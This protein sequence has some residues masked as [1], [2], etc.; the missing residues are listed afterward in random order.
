V[1]YRG[2]RAREHATS[3][4]RLPTFGPSQARGGAAKHITRGRALREVLRAVCGQTSHR[5]REKEHGVMK[6]IVAVI[7]AVPHRQ[8]PFEIACEL[9]E[10]EQ[11]T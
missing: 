2:R 6:G 7:T 5:G 9:I 10:K 1:F 8:S 3:V 4:E 11:K